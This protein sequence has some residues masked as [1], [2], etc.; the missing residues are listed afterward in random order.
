[1][2]L[3]FLSSSFQI[4]RQALKERRQDVEEVFDHP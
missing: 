3:L 2:A 4:F 1:M